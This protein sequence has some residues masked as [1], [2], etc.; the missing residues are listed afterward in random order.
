[1]ALNMVLSQKSRHETLFLMYR[2]IL[3]KDIP[4]FFIHRIHCHLKLSQSHIKTNN[5]VALFYYVTV[6]F[7][8][9]YSTKPQSFI[10]SCNNQM[11]KSTYMRE[12]S[13]FWT[14]P[15]SL[16]LH[17]IQGLFLLC[18]HSSKHSVEDVEIPLV[19]VLVSGHYP[20]LLQHIVTDG[21]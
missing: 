12:S 16:G 19:A 11:T 21:C 1:M 3:V 6:N 17:Q 7:Y 2:N 20:T 15:V 4:H 9:S 10:E 13:S 8:L 14:L 18:W 5:S